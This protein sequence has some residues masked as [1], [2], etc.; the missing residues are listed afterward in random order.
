MEI[1]QSYAGL[2]TNLRIRHSM[3]P[4][5]RLPPPLSG[6]L[7][8]PF[9]CPSPAT[10]K[11]PVVPPPLCS[12]PLLS[13]STRVRLRPG[14]RL[15]ALSQMTAADLERRETRL[16]FA[17]RIWVQRRICRSFFLVGSLAVRISLGVS[18][19]KLSE[20]RGSQLSERT[21]VGR[22]E[23]LYVYIEMPHLC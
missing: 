3:P 7:L 9:F 15:S 17:G 5:L 18:C 12:P 20:A 6:Y 16:R 1:S 10:S 4:A 19:Q 2:H 8:P 21:V 11:T 23:I 22:I 14:S 13:L